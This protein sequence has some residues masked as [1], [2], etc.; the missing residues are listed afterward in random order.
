MTTPIDVF[1]SYSHKDE[2]LRDEL[3]THLALLQ[4]QRVIRSWHDRSIVA[5]QAWQAAIDEHL[6]KARIVLLLVSA[7]FLASNYCYDIEMTRAL[8][9]HDAGEATVIPIIVRDCDWSSAPFARLQALP[10]DA[11][12]VTSWQDRDG[13]WKSV[14]LGIRAVVEKLANP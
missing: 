7:D 8:E 10:K 5:G 13:A 2:G 11:T 4:R 14:A 9:R 6:E 1:F 12:P 3:A